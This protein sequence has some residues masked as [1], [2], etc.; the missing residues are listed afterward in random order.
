M[1]KR[2]NG[3]NGDAVDGNTNPRVS[4]LVKW[5]FT[6]N[7]YI[8][9]DIG[10]LERVFQ[11]ICIKYVFQEETGEEEKTPHLQGSI[12]LKKAMRWSE[13]K[14]PKC[15]HWE[16]LRNEEASIEYCQ[17]EKTRTGRIFKWGWPKPIKVIEELYDWQKEAKEI[18]LTSC[19]ETTNR[20][21]YWWWESTGNKGK[22]AFCKY[23]AVKHKTTVI[24]GGK[25][26][27]IMNIIFNTDMDK[28]NSIIIDIPRCNKNNVSYAAIECILNGMITNT[29]YETGVKIF[30]PPQLLIFANFEPEFGIYN[31]SSDRWNIREIV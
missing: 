2:K 5:F 20:N 25:L 30:N 29:K 4:Q 8:E 9:N 6:F 27:D 28:C 16:K 1:P 15:I 18:L 11:R 12:W 3:D 23:M 14:L 7:N 24:Q 10:E 22:S 31:L 26:A 17:K 19:E 21:V 13:F